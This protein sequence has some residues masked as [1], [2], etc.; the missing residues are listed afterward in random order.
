MFP[1]LSK[2]RWAVFCST[3]PMVPARSPRRRSDFAFVAWASLLPMVAL[4]ACSGDA[5]RAG[6][7]SP[8]GAAGSEAKPGGAAA[9][10]DGGWAGAS[11]A[12]GEGGA[13]AGAG[14]VSLPRKVGT[15]ELAQLRRTIGLGGG[16]VAVGQA[17]FLLPPTP[18]PT[19]SCSLRVEGP[20][21]LLTCSF[22]GSASG[23]T[24]GG[25]G[26]S[27]PPFL[28]AGSISASGAKKPVALEF[29]DAT[30]GYGVYDDGGGPLWTGGDLIGVEGQGGPDVG[31]F[32]VQLEAPDDLVSNAFVATAFMVFAVDRDVP[33]PVAWSGGGGASTAIELV[34]SSRSADDAS[35]AT[36]ACRFDPGSSPREVP[37][38]LL[39][40]LIE[41]GDTSLSMISVNHAQLA[42]ED[43]DV[44]VRL[45]SRGLTGK[46]LLSGIGHVGPTDLAVC[47]AAVATVGAHCPGAPA[48]AASCAMGTDACHYCL[49]Q[50]P[51][52]CFTVATCDALCGLVTPGS[53]GLNAGIGSTPT[54]SASCQA[55]HCEQRLDNSYAP[56]SLAVVGDLLLS[57]T[58]GLDGLRQQSAAG[59][60]WT[61][62][63]PGTDYDSLQISSGFLFYRHAGTLER[64]DLTTGL[65][66]TLHPGA[67][68]VLRYR[69]DEA[70]L[71]HVNET[72]DV[73]AAE[74]DGQNAHTVASV[75]SGAIVGFTSSATHAYLL[76]RDLGPTVS[77][78]RASRAA[79][80]NTDPP[81]T[82]VASIPLP[83]PSSGIFAG[84][85]L[86]VLGDAAFFVQLYQTSL[87]RVDLV[88]GV[89]SHHALPIAMSFGLQ[90]FGKDLYVP[91]DA[92]VV[93]VDSTTMAITGAFDVGPVAVMAIDEQRVYFGGTEDGSLVG[94]RAFCH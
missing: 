8:G 48:S 87:T 58:V 67:K 12:G 3:V 76:L 1:D 38:S 69:A 30:T 63:Y 13:S 19:R 73:W 44:D 71:V 15:V 41:G 65:P 39:G 70:G 27:A 86:V 51:S 89:V 29:V 54:C 32:A 82:I 11:V 93:R 5:A 78:A 90:S 57:S 83:A 81:E 36:I 42:L 66:S 9:R 2:A 4:V 37:S 17:V 56:S 88:S 7:D 22:S 47:E 40:H 10:S 16:M 6:P 59:G 43:V 84:D 21:S 46:M 52:D 80:A 85:D 18:D 34:M 60:P 49:S 74:L 53:G 55:T 33:L 62:L 25:A 79:A 45:V 31:A 61:P 91:S 24:S 50:Q 92:G 75:P 72:G 64:T 94:V 68:A 20:C 23:G 14:G 28:D 26:P 77:L 35:S